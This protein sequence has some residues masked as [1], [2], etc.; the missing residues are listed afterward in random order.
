MKNAPA[1]FQRLM[2]RVT[3]GLKNVVTYIDDVVVHSSSW[4]DHVSHIEQLFERLEGAGL[5]VNLP[6][7]E[8]GKGQVTYLGHQ[9]G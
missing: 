6:K 5:V 8:F 2:N 7:C 3:T 4:S 1:T 9:V